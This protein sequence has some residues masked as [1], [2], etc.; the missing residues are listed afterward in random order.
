M[1]MTSNRS[2]VIDRAFQSR[3]H[4]TLHYPDL[5]STAKE[6]IWRQF[7][8]NTVTENKLTDEM[9]KR[10]AQL[11]T[12]GRQI[13]NIVKIAT[14]LALQEKGG[15]GIEQIDTVIRATRGTEFG[16][17]DSPP[18]AVGDQGR[19]TFGDAVRRWVP[20]GRWRGK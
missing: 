17:L 13:K 7:T 5:D 2:D 1:L 3:I 19:R 15:L 16:L 8:S 18:A 9:Y 6:H 20:I 10:L 14:L 11:P 4:L 12:D